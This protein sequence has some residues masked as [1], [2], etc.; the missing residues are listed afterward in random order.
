M[1]G[2]V[3][4]LTSRFGAGPAESALMLK[5]LCDRLAR[6]AASALESGGSQSG[7]SFC[8]L[9]VSSL[10]FCSVCFSLFISFLFRLVFLCLFVFRVF[11]YLFFLLFR[12]FC[13]VPLHWRS[14]ILC[15]W[16]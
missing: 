7:P 10:F 15:V 13:C 3:G 11:N 16:V 5:A 6:V 4:V 12:V 8:C 1:S 9:F 14:W 2:T